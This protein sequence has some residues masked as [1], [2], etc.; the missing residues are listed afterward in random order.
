MKVNKT[1]KR[2]LVKDAQRLGKLSGRSTRDQYRFHLKLG[3][4]L[5]LGVG[6]AV[7]V[8]TPMLFNS[9]QTELNKPIPQETIVK[10]TASQSIP[11]ETVA[12]TYEYTDTEAHQEI[13]DAGRQYLM[14]VAQGR[15]TVEQGKSEVRSY[16]AYLSRLSPASASSL[17]ATG[18]GCSGLW[19]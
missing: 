13:C 3:F 9:V 14:D 6:A 10:D 8:G 12:P 17:V 1:L 19:K 16:S 15:M 18:V 7:V 4:G 2:D 5:L 11:Q